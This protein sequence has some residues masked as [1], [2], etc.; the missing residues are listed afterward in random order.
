[1]KAKKVIRIIKVSFFFLNLKEL[2]Y[3]SKLFNGKKHQKNYIK[4]SN[5]KNNLNNQIKIDY[6]VNTFFQLKKNF[7]QKKIKRI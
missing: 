2:K 1:M 3:Y 4:N 6:N 7:F 5:H